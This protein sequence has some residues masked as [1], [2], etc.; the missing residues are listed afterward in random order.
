MQRKPSCHLEDAPQGSSALLAA[1]S[2]LPGPW[3][4][5][6]GSLRAAGW[7]YTGFSHLAK[8]LELELGACEAIFST[9]P[10]SPE[11]N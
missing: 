10:F 5:C 6:S 2:W 11:I 8:G 1:P 7:G 9:C 3:Q 4:A